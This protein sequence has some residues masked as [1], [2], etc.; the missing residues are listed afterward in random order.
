M[1]LGNTKVDPYEVSS[2]VMARFDEEKLTVKT[3]H[4]F[5]FVERPQMF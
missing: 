1:F 4:L 2:L 5:F 3:S